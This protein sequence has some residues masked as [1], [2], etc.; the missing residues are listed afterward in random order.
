KHLKITRKADKFF[1][2]DLG[3][4]N[5]TWVKG[6]LIIP[7]EAVEV[8][9]G[10]LIVIG[11]VLANL[12]RKPSEDYLATQYSI[13]L[14]D[15]VVEREENL[16]YKSTLTTNRRRLEKIHEVS[17]FLTQSLDIDEICEKIMDSLFYCLK[18]I[19]SGIVLLIDSK[20]GELEERI[21]RSRDSKK[22]IKMRYSRTIVDRVIREGKALMMA[23]TRHEDQEKIS[24]SIKMMGLRSIMCAPLISK[25]GIRGAIYV[26]STSALPGFPKDDLFLLAGLSIPAAMAVENALLYSKRRQNEEALGDSV[27]QWHTTFDAMRDAVSILDPE[28][29]ILRCN[30]AMSKFLGKPIREII[31]HR[32][33]E[34]V[35]CTTQPIEGC[36]VLL[37]R[38]TRTREMLVLLMGER[39]FEVVADPVFDKHGK[40]IEAV[41]IISDITPRKQ[42][43]EVLQKAHEILEKRVE[44]RTAELI[45]AN[46]KLEAEITDRKQAEE[47]LRGSEERYKQLI[48]NANDPIYQTNVDGHFTF[49][50]PIFQRVMEYSKDELIGKH[51]LELI[52]PDYRKD[53]NKFYTMQFAKK[54]PNTYYEFPAITK[55]GK[56]I[57]IGQ[58]VQLT[59][60]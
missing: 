1:V 24:D 25:S 44:K 42:A 40:I 15:L 20:T 37:M 58:N 28:G 2:E 9:E 53:A 48:D 12:G 4:Q 5:G 11:A 39:W 22:D 46:K 23:D 7:K 51:Y 56:E 21:S 30:K 3:S 59:L 60:E 6:Q 36:P 32:C 34:L 54:I 16:L 18:E 14:S 50:N 47:A 35:H 41:H 29:K 49:C 27:R 8:E 57:W 38:K 19:D 26:H 43:E 33:W 17:T 13:D 31:G 10:V 55:N 45:K 52:N